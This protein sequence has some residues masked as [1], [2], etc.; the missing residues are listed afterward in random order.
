MKWFAFALVEGSQD[1]GGE[2]EV[3]GGKIWVARIEVAR[4]LNNLGIGRNLEEEVRLL[5]SDHRVDDHIIARVSGFEHRDRQD[6]PPRIGVCDGTLDRKLALGDIEAIQVE[7]RR[8][9]DRQRDV[10]GRCRRVGNAN[11]SDRRDGK[12][13]EDSNGSGTSAHLGLL[14]HSA[15]S[16]CVLTAIQDFR[17]RPPRSAPI[18][19]A[20]GRSLGP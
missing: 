4:D 5:R 2:I 9:S 11:Q 7:V 1:T 18:E 3:G 19:S 16:P 8:R 10:G 15:P 17:D 6:S 13:G 20:L 12:K 14:R